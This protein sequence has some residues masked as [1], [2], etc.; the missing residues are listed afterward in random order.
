MKNS[1]KLLLLMALSL[2]V[3]A[4]VVRAAKPE[5]LVQAA[6]TPA[7]VQTTQQAQ[8]AAP[9]GVLAQAE[10]EQNEATEPA[11]TEAN[12]PSEATEPAG[13]DTDNLQEG[14]QNGP[15]DG[16]EGPEDSAK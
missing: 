14:D 3:A 8:P 16:S 1:R 10:Q 13:A 5:L 15:D 12:D 11:G 6:Q 4:G 7:Q 9:A 2:A